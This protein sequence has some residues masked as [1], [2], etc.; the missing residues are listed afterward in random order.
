LPDAEEGA[1]AEPDPGEII[2][3]EIEFILHLLVQVSKLDDGV[4]ELELGTKQGLSI[5]KASIPMCDVLQMPDLS[6]DWGD[7]GEPRLEMI[8][9]NGARSEAMINVSVR[10][11]ER[12]SR[13]LLANPEGYSPPE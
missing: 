12:A 6:R 3:L 4:L 2:E 13:A 11:L 9:P 1:P 8:G 5:G 10:G 7:Q